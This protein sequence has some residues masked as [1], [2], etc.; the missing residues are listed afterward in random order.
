MRDDVLLSKYVSHMT[1][2]TFQVGGCDASDSGNTQ[3]IASSTFGRLGP[4]DGTRADV[5]QS[6]TAS[7]TGDELYGS[8]VD[9]MTPKTGESQTLPAQSDVGA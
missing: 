8:S 6:G 1:V 4:C 7:F 9:S 3:Q 2:N 5:L